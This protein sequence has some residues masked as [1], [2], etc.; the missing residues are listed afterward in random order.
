M[1]FIKQSAA[2]S[3][4]LLPA[5]TGKGVPLCHKTAAASGAIAHQ[6]FLCPARILDKQMGFIWDKVS[7]HFKYFNLIKKAG[8]GRL[9]AF[10]AFCHQRNSATIVS[11][12]ATHSATPATS[13]MRT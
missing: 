12:A 1:Q 11:A 6:G 5:Q 3:M 10:G 9:K 13:A 7:R 8:K 4:M 2:G